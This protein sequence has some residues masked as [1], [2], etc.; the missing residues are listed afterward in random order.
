MA[1]KPNILFFHVDNLGMGELGC[2]GGGMLRGADTKRMDTFAKQGAKLT[3][4]VVEPQCTPTRSALMTGRFPIRS[5]NHTIALGGNGGGIVTWERTIGVDPVG[6]RLRHR[7]STASG[8]SAPKTAASR[9]ITVLTNGTAPC[10]PMTNACGRPIRITCRSATASRTCM[11]ASRARVR[12][13]AGRAA[14]HGNQ[15]DLRPR[16]PEARHQVHGEVGQ[17]RTSRST[18]TSTTR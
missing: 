6:S 15:E 10:A 8:T 5:G 3:H 12:A 16:V 18:A 14:H 2:Y 9:P 4:Y 1:K 17:G 7:R 13:A 11:K